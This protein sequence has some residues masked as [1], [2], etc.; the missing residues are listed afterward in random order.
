MRSRAIAG[1]AA[2]LLCSCASF[3]SADTV[4]SLGAPTFPRTAA[5]TTLNTSTGSATITNDVARDGSGSL[6][7]ETNGGNKAAATYGGDRFIG[8]PNLGTF[9][10][11]LAAGGS[12]GF[13][14]YR[15][16]SSTVPAHFAPA[17]EIS[18][19]NGANLK[20]E[21]V[22]DGFPTVSPVATDT[23]YSMNFDANNGLF[24][25]YNGSVVT[26]GGAQQNLTLQGW[27]DS[28]LGK[29]FELST[30]ITGISVQAGSGW[31]AGKFVGYV[32]NVHLIFG[33]GTAENIVANFEP[34]APAESSTPLP[35][36]GVGGAV[37]LG[38]MGFRRGPKRRS[39]AQA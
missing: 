35:V 2:G 19:A 31:G 18:F 24:Y 38:A 13:D 30:K 27:L 29:D 21:A 10:D 3:V 14:F 11:L 12:V 5:W 7:L 6:R 16:S 28:T 25:Q 34:A 1:L 15:D 32:D 9:G 22:Y 39:A 37:L 26:S 33:S 36:A 8:S 23:W 17:L 4:T 20:W